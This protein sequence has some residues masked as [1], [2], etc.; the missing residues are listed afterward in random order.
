VS[1]LKKV[2]CDHAKAVVQPE[3][4]LSANNI[5]NPSAEATALGRKFCSKVW[6][7]GGREITDEAFRKGEKESHD[8]LEEAT[9]TEEA[10]E[11]ARIIGTFIMT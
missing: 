2:G 10:S 1:V 4:T 5:K 6:L 3:F 7:K 8:A 11:H 9:K